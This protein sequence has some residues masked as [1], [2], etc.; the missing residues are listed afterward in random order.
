MGG[1]IVPIGWQADDYFFNR[2]IG[3]IFFKEWPQIFGING[4]KAGGNNLEGVRNGDAGTF[5]AVINCKNSRQV[6][7]DNGI[8]KNG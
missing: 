4:G 3:K 2:F 8:M 1:G 5:S 7:M 6:L